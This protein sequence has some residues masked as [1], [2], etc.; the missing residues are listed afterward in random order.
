[1]S[2]AD[3]VG[4][5]AAAALDRVRALWRRTGRLK[6]RTR[7]TIAATLAVALGIGGG[8]AFA[9]LAVR[10]ELYGG[11]DRQLGKQVGALQRLAD[12]KARPNGPAPVKFLPSGSGPSDAKSVVV[13]PRR[14]FGD[15]VDYV[16]IVRATGQPLLPNDQ[17]ARLPVDATDRAV[18]AGTAA[19]QLRTISFQGTDVRLA[20]A[21]LGQGVAIQVALP[22]TAAEDQLSQLG[23]ELL[24]AGLA[25]ILL[26]GGLGWWVTRTALRPVGQLTE[27]A[28]RIAA[29]R[30]LAHRIDPGDRAER[31]ELGRLAVS[32]NAMLSAVQDSTER[33]RQLVADA[34]HELR[35]PLT[36][37][38][39]NV[40]VLR[41][42]ELLDPDD[43]ERL[44]VSVLAGIDDLT[45][46]VADTVELARGEEPAAAFE[47]LD[48]AEVAGNV[49]DRARLH[50][51]GVD[52]AADLAAT[53]IV[54]VPDRIQRAMA[55]LLDNAA[56]FSGGAGRVEVTLAGHT[57]TVRDHGP[58]IPEGDLPHVFDRF[59]RAASMRDRPGSGL[60]LAIVAQVAESH[61]GAVS[62]ANHPDG[63]AVLSLRLPEPAEPGERGV[64]RGV[65]RVAAD[66]RGPAQ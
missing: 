2:A 11:I 45:G 25:G 27:A 66:R 65:L 20:T 30:D 31:D 38:R 64:P 62:A 40:E 46:L 60:G 15:S 6:L 48:W 37:L 39:T 3:R 56:K 32:F 13:G 33:Q 24:G 54:A 21:P 19:E 52:F 44:I 34:S 55:N 29:T 28:E 7:I 16:Q 23:L 59:Y 4:R 47:Q 41:K 8:V 14:R 57:L 22:L 51:P 9:Y 53:R 49:V 35:T 36:S 43:R 10:A 5:S 26:A 42:I 12:E 50:W 61:G 17:T 58:G 18:A 1:M 63:G